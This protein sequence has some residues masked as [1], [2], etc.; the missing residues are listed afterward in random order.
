VQLLASEEYGL[1]CLLRVAGADGEAPVSIAE[2]AEAEG[3]SSDY[4]A[5]LM[6]Q[7]RLGS[8]VTSVRGAEGGYRLARPAD[9]IS[10]W[11]AV[12]VLG[13]E[14]FTERFCACHPGLRRR[15]VRNNDC[16]LRSLWGRLQASVRG[17]LEGI[18]LQDLCRDELAMSNWLNDDETSPSSWEEK[19]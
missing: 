3:L 9:A 7:L 2:I 12:L 1:R 14:F 5:K 16:S 17:T 4:T 10:V 18:T 15:C 8:L 13:G 11:S 19:T 6:R